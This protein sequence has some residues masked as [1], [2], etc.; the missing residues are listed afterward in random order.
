MF[1]HFLEAF[2]LCYEWCIQL[3]LGSVVVKQYFVSAP[4][5]G[6]FCAPAS[7]NLMHQG[8]LFGRLSSAVTFPGMPYSCSFSRFSLAISR[9]L[10]SPPTPSRNQR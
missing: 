7:V 10:L 6:E 1:V 4:G 5:H 9:A 3:S 8:Y 2:N